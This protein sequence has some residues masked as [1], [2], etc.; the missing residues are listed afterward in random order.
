MEDDLEFS[1]PLDAPTEPDS[2]NHAAAGQKRTAPD[3]PP[4]PR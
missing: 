3:S 1:D 4:D 2:D